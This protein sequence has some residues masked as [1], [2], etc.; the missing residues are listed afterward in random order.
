MD[1]VVGG[2]YHHF[3]GN[4]YKVLMIGTDSE[5]L[6][7]VVIYESLDDGQIWVRPHEMFVSKVD[8][9]KYPKVSQIYRF[10]LIN[11]D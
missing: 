3:K 5:T 8:R 9:I 1:V 10:E 7:K 4:S 6:Q 11:N 2:T